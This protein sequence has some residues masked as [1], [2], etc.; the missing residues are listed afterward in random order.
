M[1]TDKQERNLKTAIH[2]FVENE[3]K[4]QYKKYISNICVEAILYTQLQ[5][6]L[7]KLTHKDLTNNEKILTTAY[8]AAISLFEIALEKFCESNDNGQG[9]KISIEFAMYL[10][11]NWFPDDKNDAPVTECAYAEIYWG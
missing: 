4:Q 6:Q 1:L 11:E 2:C 7:S 3:L 5:I 10:S 8:A 9:H